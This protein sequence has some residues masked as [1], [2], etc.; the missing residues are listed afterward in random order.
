MIKY[1]VENNYVCNICGKRLKRQN[2]LNRHLRLHSGTKNYGCG[3][4]DAT[5]C[6]AS[7]LR[8]HKLNRHMEVEETALCTFCGKGFTNKA[9][10]ELHITLHTGEKRYKCPQCKKR[11]RSRSAYQNHMRYHKGRKEFVC[12]YCG[13]AFMQRAHRQ[14]HTA[15]HTG[16]RNHVCT[17]C[18]KA[19]IEP[20][21]M[22]K[23]LR[24][25]SKDAT[26][27]R[28]DSLASRDG[29]KEDKERE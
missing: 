29:A 17:V 6:T 22:R 2:N 13:K 8:N 23:H 12:T 14:Q 18:Q 1:T 21:D 28:T 24:T 25:H 5:Y 3:V 27:F 15:T 10:R 11:F 7:A 4:C 16:E 9:K 20:G 19:F 26:D